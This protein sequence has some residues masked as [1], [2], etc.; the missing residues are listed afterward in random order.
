MAGDGI[1]RTEPPVSEPFGP[2][3]RDKW[4]FD[5]EKTLERWPWVE[6]WLITELD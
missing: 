1:S 4:F 5:P 3:L 2:D 6:D